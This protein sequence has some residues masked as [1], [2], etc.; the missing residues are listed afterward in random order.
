MVA[1]ICSA[2]GT[3]KKPDVGMTAEGA[4]IVR[5]RRCGH[6]RTVRKRDL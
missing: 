3:H 6:E 5:C 2:C 4:A 1:F